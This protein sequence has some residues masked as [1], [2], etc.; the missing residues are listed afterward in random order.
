MTGATGRFGPTGPV[1]RTGPT[2]PQGLP[3]TAANTGTTGSSGSTGITGPTGPQGLQG[4]P[5]SASNTGASGSTGITGR[6]GQTGPSGSTGSTGQ[7]GR[8]GPTG[9]QGLPGTASNTGASGST[10]I[11]GPTGPQGLPGS[12]SNTGASGSTGIT[13][14]TGPT[15]WS[16]ES[17]NDIN[18][19]AGNVSIGKTGPQ[20]TLDILGNMRISN[21]LITN[22]QINNLSNSILQLASNFIALDYTTGTTF[23]ISNDVTRTYITQPFTVR[24][25]NFIPEYVQNNTIRIKLIMDVSGNTN[26]GYCNSL[27]LSP[28]PNAVATTYVPAML[29]GLSS[30]NLLNSQIIIQDINIINIANVIKITTDVNSYSIP[31][32]SILR[33]IDLF[34]TGS[35]D[36][37]IDITFNISTGDN[38]NTY[39]VTATPTV[40]DPVVQTFIAFM[41]VY[42]IVNLQSGMTYSIYIVSNVG[43]NNPITSPTI[44]Y[45]TLFPPPTNFT[46]IANTDTSITVSFTA[47]DGQIDSYT[48]YAA[49][50]A[51][52]SSVGPITFDGSATTYVLSGLQRGSGYIINL[53]A[54]NASGSSAL[55]SITSN[56]LLLPPTDVSANSS[57]T[58]TIAI[59]FTE[60]SNVIVYSYSVYATYS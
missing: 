8:T 28:N 42:T 5:G 48:I 4:L 59:S 25:E 27:L 33:S 18:Y 44:T 7:T 22:K 40:G 14:P 43:S 19:T 12:A 51:D 36:T 13:G 60:P 26:N 32:N 6:T 30:L 54:N 1:G 24:L 46:A 31:N 37:T 23:T 29:N 11:T 10:G 41:N 17:N 2:G 49:T 56:T 53:V 57:T 20:Y 16:L 38:V 35:T 58:S 9:P 39:T 3:G 15:L 45:R 55:A 47:P 21:A 34:P 50:Y 52:D